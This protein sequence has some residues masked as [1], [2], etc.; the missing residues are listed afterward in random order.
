[1]P[2][3]ASAAA[4]K[5]YRVPVQLASNRLLVSCTIEGQGP[6]ALGIDT[7]GVVSMIDSDLATRLDLR[8]RGKTGLGIAGRHDLF[9]MFEAR[10]VIFANAF[11]QERVLLA[12]LEDMSLG[13][14]VVGMLSAG[15]LTTMDAELDLSAMQWRL[16]PEG[17]PDRSGW[18]AHE[19]AIRPTK[20][21]SPHLFGEARLGGQK[22]RC[23]F[24]TGAPPPI[25]LSFKS[26][27]KVG[28][29]INRQNWSPALANGRDA[30]I[31]R[32]N[33]PLEIGGLTIERPLISVSDGP[34]GWVDDGIVGLGLIRRLNLATE[35]KARR[36]W[37]RPSGLPELP[38]RYSISGLW[39]DEK[40]K[41]L[42]VQRVGTGSPAERAGIAPGDRINGLRL[43]E[44]IGMLGGKPGDRVTLNVSRGGASRNVTLVLEPYV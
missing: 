8:K 7:G 35:I 41:D 13:G 1:M 14:D 26:A 15:C 24:D 31:Y 20:V 6:F 17:G 33:Q 25:S 37:T 4:G 23:L 28:I 10:E 44:L 43:R 11:R 32:S 39:T 40:G 3:R 21:G 19:D 30:R 29:D 38:E 5:V 27:R 36:L 18:I 42:V 9:Q 2:F 34:P 16:Y 22:L 12:G